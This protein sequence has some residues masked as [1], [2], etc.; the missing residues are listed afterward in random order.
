M[1]IFDFLNKNKSSNAVKGMV[2]VQRI[3]EMGSVEKLSKS[4]IVSL[5]TNLQDASKNLNKW[6]Y[7][8]VQ[9]VYSNYRK[10]TDLITMDVFKYLDVCKEIIAAYESSVPYFLFDGNYSEHMSK[11][12]AQDIWV[13]YDD[14]LRFEDMEELIFRGTISERVN[15]IKQKR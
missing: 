6:Q 12:M 15:E 11:E 1:A 5:I 9:T 14:G 13:L 10:Q 7:S 8:F 4:Q 3:K 2:A